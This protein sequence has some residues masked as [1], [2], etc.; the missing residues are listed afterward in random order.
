M[1]K[2][3]H[4]PKKKIHDPKKKN[5]R[6]TYSH[7]NIGKLTHFQ[8]LFDNDKARSLFRIML[9]L[10]YNYTFLIDLPQNG[11]PFGC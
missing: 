2:N 8:R 10:D 4:D 9:N 11:I 7:Y 1:E 6:F 5:V 3:V